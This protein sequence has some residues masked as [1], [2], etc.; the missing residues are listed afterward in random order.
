MQDIYLD[1]II[2]RNFW[3]LFSSVYHGLNE[4]NNISTLNVFN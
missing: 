3:Y 1:L 4:Y 2:E